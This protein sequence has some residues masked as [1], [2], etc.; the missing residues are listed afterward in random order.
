[1]TEDE[2]H[3]LAPLYVVDALDADEV[4]TF[5]DHL[6]GCTSCADT[7]AELSEALVPLSEGLEVA[8]PP[9]LRQRVLAEAATSAAVT[10]T[11][12]TRRRAPVWLAAAAAAVVA[13]GG[14]W[15]AEQWLDE[16]PTEQVVQAEDAQRHSAPTDGGQL[17][18]V[19]SAARDRAVITLPDDVESP[20]RE[21]VYQAWFIGEDGSARSAGVLSQDALE[22]RE[23]LLTG[24]PRGAKAVALTVEPAG[25]STQPTQDPFAIVPLG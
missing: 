16:S 3:D 23:A 1:M 15:V 17:V 2:L 4:V 8:P 9:Q 19:T 11:H 20:E 6:R 10:P 18:V 25:G 14:A 22:G 24:S 21:Q 12:R 5:E 7:V 13:A